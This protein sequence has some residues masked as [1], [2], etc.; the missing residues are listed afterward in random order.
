MLTVL[1]VH[2]GVWLETAKDMAQG[3]NILHPFLIQ[4]PARTTRHD[5]RSP[6]NKFFANGSHHG[7]NNN[8]CNNNGNDKSSRTSS[9]THDR[10]TTSWSSD[11]AHYFLRYPNSSIKTSP[12]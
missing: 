6:A 10:N 1:C 3:G 9:Q 12:G 8:G 5:R 2:A 7:C 11:S 4:N